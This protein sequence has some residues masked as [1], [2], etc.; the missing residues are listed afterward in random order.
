M[1]FFSLIASSLLLC[2]CAD[3][4]VTRTYNSSTSART[5]VDAK[6]FGSQE[7]V[8]YETNCGVGATNPTAIYIRPFCIGGAIFRGDETASEG[9]MPIRKALT[10]VAFAADLKEELSKLA[11]ARILADD[12]VPKV[13]WLVEGQFDLVDGGDPV[14]RFFFGQFGAGRS[15]LVLH[16]KVTDVVA[17]RVVYEFDMAGGSRGQGKL[18]TIRASGLGKATPFD[19][20]NAAERVLLVLSPDPFRFGARSSVTLR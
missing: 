15:F 16:V 11:P 10:P 18:G 4:V 14:A 2:S 7:T 6:D 3:M 12:E 9:E 5:E 8:R 20:R 17:R 1:K 13:G 19:L